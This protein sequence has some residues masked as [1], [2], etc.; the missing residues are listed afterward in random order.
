MHA[1]GEW[2]QFVDAYENARFLCE[3]YYNAAPECTFQLCSRKW[4]INFAVFCHLWRS[5]LVAS[6]SAVA[7]AVACDVLAHFVAYTCGRFEENNC[8]SQNTEK[9]CY[10]FPWKFRCKMVQS[11]APELF[12]H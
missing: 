10:H 11:D 5:V 6:C 3:D 8:A 9:K 2:M 4:L 7:V 1:N 12:G